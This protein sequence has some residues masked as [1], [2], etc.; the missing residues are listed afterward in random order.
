[1]SK[2][3]SLVLVLLSTQ[4]FAGKMDLGFG[5]YSLEA[6]TSSA[7]GSSANLGLYRAN[8]AMDLTR[9][10]DFNVG[11]TLIMSNIVGGDL[12]YGFDFG[13][14]WYPLGPSAPI[15]GG[16]E[17]LFVKIEPTY[18][19]FVELSFHQRQFQSV[20]SSYA[21]FGIALGA[22][23]DFTDSYDLKASARFISL[24]GPSG[25]SASELSLSFGVVFPFSLK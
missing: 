25:S 17:G 13:V 11:Y 3:L 6:K 9:N 21:G 5:F 10:L 7:S 16:V 2:W 14:S 12:G 20:Q 18:R 24:D 22:E 15:M 1:M 23:R 4:A 19:P 8:Y